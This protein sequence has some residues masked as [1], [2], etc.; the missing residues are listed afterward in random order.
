MAIILN[1]NLIKLK[2]LVGWDIRVNLVRKLEKEWIKNF[3]I[4]ILVC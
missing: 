2:D 4:L 3:M 1:K